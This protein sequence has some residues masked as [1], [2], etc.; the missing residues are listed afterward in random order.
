M[1]LYSYTAINTAG[2]RSQGVLTCADRQEA[3]R[4]LLAHGWH[5]VEL[6]RQRAPAGGKLTPSWLVG[7]GVK[8][9]PLTR[10]LATLLSSGVPLARALEVLIEQTESPRARGCLS[11]VLDS[12]RGGADLSAALGARPDV[13]PEIMVSMVRVGEAS[14]NLDTLLLRLAELF[15]KQEEARGEVRAALAYPLLVLVLSLASALV[16]MLAVVPRFEEL[17][18]GVGGR[19]PLPTRVLCALSRLLVE[20]WWVVAAGLVLLAVAARAAGRSARVSA[21]WDRAKLRLPVA[22]RLY[23]HAAVARFARSLGTLAQAEVPIVEALGVVEAAAGNAAYAASIGGMRRQVQQGVALAELMRSEGVFPPLAV[24][25]VAV[26][27]ETGRLDQMLLRV[28]A[29][30]DREA[31]NMTKLMTSLLAPALILG[32]AVI[33]AFIIASLVL[34]IFQLSAGVA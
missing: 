14:S 32:V 11:G 21:A 17:F 26:G 3:V 7:S 5:V 9:A 30:Y 18:L 13:F 34:P 20:G 31:A 23:R 28:A 10:Q 15:E 8:L 25:M 27:E 29:I 1:D 24:Q 22:G 12:V 2:E 4:R 19:L 33:V 16:L 6:R